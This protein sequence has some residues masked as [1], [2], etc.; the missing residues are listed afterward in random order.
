LVPLYQQGPAD[1]AAHLDQFFTENQAV[2]HDV[3]SKAEDLSAQSAF[4]FQPEALMIFDL[5]QTERLSVRDR[6]IHAYPFEEL[7][8]I[9]NAFGISFD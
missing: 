7:E 2:L 5:L 9:A 8:R 3:Y 1:I 4:L 6:W